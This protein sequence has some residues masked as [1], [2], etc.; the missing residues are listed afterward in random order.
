MQ[1]QTPRH[2]SFVGHSLFRGEKSEFAS[3]LGRLIARGRLIA[4]GGLQ[5]ECEQQLEAEHCPRWPTMNIDIHLY[6]YILIIH[7][8]Y[9]RSY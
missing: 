4:A 6:I 5:R 2:V 7:V 9:T 3:F 8:I 1:K